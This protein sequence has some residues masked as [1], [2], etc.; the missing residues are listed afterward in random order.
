MKAA[1]E[2]TTLELC[3]TEACPVVH[4]VARGAVFHPSC[5]E[6]LR[7]RIPERF[8][9]GPF[10][11]NVH[12]DITNRCA[13]ACRHCYHSLAPGQGDDLSLAR[14]VSIL[15]D[16][17]RL[18]CARIAL[19]GGEPMLHPEFLQILEA[20]KSRGLSLMALFTGGHPFQENLVG[21]VQKIFPNV[22]ILVSL[23][24]FNS[25]GSQLRG[26]A[27]AIDEAVARYIGMGF[28]VCVSS[29]MHRGWK[30]TAVEAYERMRLR[31][32]WLWRWRVSVPRR[33]GRFGQ[34][35]DSFAM[36]PQ[37]VRRQYS[38]ML[39][40][41]LGLFDTGAQPLPELQIGFAF[42][43]QM[44]GQRVR[45]YR[46]KEKLCRYKHDTAVVNWQ[47]HVGHCSMAL[48]TGDRLGDL[49]HESL[50]D[51]WRTVGERPAMRNRPAEEVAECRDCDIRRY[52]NSGCRAVVP[53]GWDCVTYRF[54][55]EECL[56]E[57]VR[58]GTTFEDEKTQE[59]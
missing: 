22:L 14:I 59:E 54:F 38:E 52:C 11:D 35:S 3:G 2:T 12:M 32:P 8:G 6:E 57:L 17:R 10:L 9:P 36:D 28:K 31:H 5:V 25:D 41:Y 15:D 27:E 45:L 7:G 47:G 56:P 20:V 21:R 44:I 53:D 42:Q 40:H 4:D 24:D 1:T 29:L 39:R 34:G 16:A 19:S 18:G 48:S 58:R 33:I 49:E 13:S 46:S 51:I 23:D 26:S 50:F 37:E 43:S 55:A 30:C